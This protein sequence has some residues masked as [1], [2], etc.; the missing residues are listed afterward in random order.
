MNDEL[1]ALLERAKSRRPS[2]EE[3]EEQALENAFANGA[4]S[5]SRITRETIRATATILAQSDKPND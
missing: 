2:Q 5:D 3:R 4:L 1:K